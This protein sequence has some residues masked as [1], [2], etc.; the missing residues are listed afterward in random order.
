MVCRQPSGG[1]FFKKRTG[2]S[3]TL[4]VSEIA[5]L[6]FTSVF[7]SDTAL[8]EE[9]VRTLNDPLWAL[10]RK[11][12]D[13]RQTICFYLCPFLVGSFLIGPPVPAEVSQKAC[14]SQACS[15][16]RV[17]IAACLVVAAVWV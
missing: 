9:P 15:D 17:A 4:A 12:Y 2:D 7:K 14:E 16:A 10:K 3:G 6:G 5:R 13:S 1:Q 11:S 8:L